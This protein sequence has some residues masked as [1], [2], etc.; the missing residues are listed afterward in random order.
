MHEWALA[1]A[2]VAAIA[3]SI[4]GGAARCEVRLVLGELQAIDL[5]VFRYALE[6]LSAERLGGRVSYSFEREPAVFRCNRC[7][8]QWPLRDVELSEGELEA[9]HFLPEAVHTMIACPACGSPDFDV[10][11]GRGVWIKSVS[12]R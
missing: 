6:V 2:V 1:E 7:G 8:R 3:G 5:E 4:R 10:V 12:C 9:I 11:K